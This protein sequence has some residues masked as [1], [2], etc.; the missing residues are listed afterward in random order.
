MKVLNLNSAVRRVYHLSLL[1]L[2]VT[3]TAHASPSAEA[4]AERKRAKAAAERFEMLSMS[5]NALTPN[6]APQISLD[7]PMTV[8]EQDVNDNTDAIMAYSLG[9]PQKQDMIIALAALCHKSPQDCIEHSMDTALNANGLSGEQILKQTVEKIV[10]V[11]AAV[12]ADSSSPPSVRGLSLAYQALKDPTIS[13]FKSLDMKSRI[14]TSDPEEQKAYQQ[15]WVNAI[16]YLDRF[17]KNSDSPNARAQILGALEKAFGNSYRPGMLPPPEFKNALKDPQLKALYYGLKGGPKNQKTTEEMNAVLGQNAKDLNK[18][19]LA[20]LEHLNSQTAPPTEEEIKL[21]NQ[22]QEY[23]KTKRSIKDVEYGLKIA[24]DLGVIFNN[25]SAEFNHAIAYGSATIK[26]IDTVLDLKNQNISNITSLVAASSIVGAVAMLATIGKQSP[27]EARFQAIMSALRGISE[28]LQTIE[29]RLA[30]MQ[31]EMR[32]Y[33][34][35]IVD[36]SRT[37]QVTLYKLQEELDKLVTMEMLAQANELAKDQNDHI[38]KN[39]NFIEKLGVLKASYKKNEA[40]IGT[41]LVDAT[42]LVKWQSEPPFVKPASYF[43]DLNDPMGTLSGLIKVLNFQPSKELK[44]GYTNHLGTQTAN[45]ATLMQSLGIKMKSLGPDTMVNPQT[46]MITLANLNLLWEMIEKSSLSKGIDTGATLEKIRSFLAKSRSTLD[47]VETDLTST[48]LHRLIS[49]SFVANYGQLKS[50]VEELYQT[51]ASNLRYSSDTITPKNCNGGT[52]FMTDYDPSTDPDPV[53]INLL[54]QYIPAEFRMAELL[55]IGKVRACIDRVEWSWDDPRRNFPGVGLSHHRF[56]DYHVYVDFKFHSNLKQEFGYQLPTAVIGPVSPTIAQIYGYNPDTNPN[57]Y[58]PE[59]FEHKPIWHLSMRYLPGLNHGA[60]SLYR[61]TGISS[62]GLGKNNKW[63]GPWA[64]MMAR[65]DRYPSVGSAGQEVYYF[66]EFRDAAI[67]DFYSPARAPGL[68]ER[69]LKNYIL[70]YLGYEFDDYISRSRGKLQNDGKVENLNPES[71]LGKMISEAIGNVERYKKHNRKFVTG[72]EPDAAR[73]EALRTSLLPI[74]DSIDRLKEH[75]ALMG[76]IMTMQQELAGN[77]SADCA[78][79]YN[80]VEFTAALKGVFSVKDSDRSSSF[81]RR[82]KTSYG[83]GQ[84]GAYACASL[85]PTARTGFKREL[86]TAEFYFGQ[87]QSPSMWDRAIR[88]IG[89]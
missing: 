75:S 44:G 33:F 24:S 76:L 28:Q 29:K 13:L 18:T 7:I 87:I 88:W 4:E 30:S 68:G 69:L 22:K 37:N 58:L 63:W 74:W 64:T 82:F 11:G 55:G 60:Y 12:G 59:F 84:T 14:L 45:M 81:A 2:L 50:H 17:T 89:W 15:R 9:D 70:T 23:A 20:L 21:E 67:P 34:K 78:K 66:N 26:V 16:V 57:M 52:D 42:D 48:D 62:R 8:T 41:L 27:E 51:L 85:S 79:A 40:D 10:D 53:R 65:N 71:S 35:N 49:K 46:S 43:D 31:Q 80:S 56:F 77:V 73:T 36:I 83:R 54:P 38:N 19:T 61:F 32:Y 47:F 72:S 5:G 86:E 1:S 25:T 6:G 3:S 39:E